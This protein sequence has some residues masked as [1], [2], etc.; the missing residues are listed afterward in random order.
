MTQVVSAVL[1]AV[2]TLRFSL[3]VGWAVN[4]PTDESFTSVHCIC[5][6]GDDPD[7]G[8]EVIC[9]GCLSC[10]NNLFS[11][12]PSNVAS[13]VGNRRVASTIPVAGLGSANLS[14]GPMLREMTL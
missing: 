6:A 11:G 3:L 5:T 10:V 9:G 7:I 12:N 14:T 1:G 8:S 13:A 2:F 4:G